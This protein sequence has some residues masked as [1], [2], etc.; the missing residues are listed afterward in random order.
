MLFTENHKKIKIRNEFKEALGKDD[1]LYEKWVQYAERLVRLY[2]N[3][4][5]FY[6]QGTDVVAELV[7]KTIE[8][9]RVWDMERVSLSTFMY[10]NIKSVIYDKCQR[11]YKKITTRDNCTTIN[12]N[13]E[14]R[15][16]IDNFAFTDHERIEEAYT[17]KEFFNLLEKEIMDDNECI[18]FYLGIRENRYN[19][20]KNK[21]ISE[22]LGMNVKD[23][24]NLKK[25]FMRKCDNVFLKYYKSK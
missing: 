18:E 20:T 14:T 16:G 8:G 22:V 17:K 2:S 11:E 3:G 15:I 1:G 5:E 25:R 23:V 9:V 12:D 7:E 21:E 13:T 4:N 24:E 10:K 19:H 6:F